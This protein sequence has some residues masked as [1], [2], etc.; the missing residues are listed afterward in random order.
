[1]RCQKYRN[2]A[3][4]KR[5]LPKAM[6]LRLKHVVRTERQ[7]GRASGG[8][9]SCH[10]LGSGGEEGCQEGK[11]GRHLS[12][13]HPHWAER[14][15]G[16]EIYQYATVIMREYGNDTKGGEINSRKWAGESAKQSWGSMW[17]LEV[18]RSKY[19]VGKR[20]SRIAGERSRASI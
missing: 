17:R 10:R 5:Y 7:R 9:V 4:Y 15:I 12:A 1:M 16:K 14:L 2:L 20:E 11:Y 19:M 13:K 6:F 8:L 3:K 18:N